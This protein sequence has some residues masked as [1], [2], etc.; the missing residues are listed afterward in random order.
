MSQPS[1]TL[2][3]SIL[4]KDMLLSDGSIECQVRHS[5]GE[6]RRGEGCCTSTVEHESLVDVAEPVNFVIGTLKSDLQLFF[7]G[8]EVLDMAD[9]C[10]QKH[11]YKELI[12]ELE[13]IT[14]IKDGDF[15]CLLVGG[16]EGF[17][18]ASVTFPELVASSL[19]GL[20]AL[21]ANSF[22]AGVTRS[23]GRGNGTSRFEFLVVV[24]VRIVMSSR[25]RSLAPVDSASGGPIG[26]DRDGVK[27]LRSGNGCVTGR[28]V[29]SAASAEPARGEGIRR[30]FS[31]TEIVGQH[32]R[33]DVAELS[34]R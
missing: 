23:I 14:A 6:R 15:A 9:G 30:Q 5:V 12:I 11:E 24:V 19:L 1:D 33:G 28:G 4:I 32:R 21:L 16:R 13:F 26:R 22:A 29:T 34:G 2:T 10:S 7:D 27:A 17:L 18:E 20:D 3:T 25:S 31:A 8:L